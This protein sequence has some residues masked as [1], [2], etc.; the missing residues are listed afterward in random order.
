M[1]ELAPEAAPPATSLRAR[2]FS[3]AREPLWAALAAVSAALAISFLA[4]LATGKDPLAGYGHMLEG[5]L[6]GF[7]PLGESALKGSVLVLTGLSVAVAFT[8]GLRS[9]ERV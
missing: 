2:L 3:A 4:I 6:G 8:V 7:G 1:A 9:E 5:A